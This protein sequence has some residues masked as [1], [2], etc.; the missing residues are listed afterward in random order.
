MEEGEI[1]RQKDQER[2]EEPVRA[3]FQ[4]QVV[5]FGGS[6]HQPHAQIYITRIGIT[7]MRDFHL[8]IL[9]SSLVLYLLY[10]HD[11]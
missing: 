6:H 3:S 9:P 4:V 5:D 1:G 11:Q 2:V 8:L 10:R 7:P